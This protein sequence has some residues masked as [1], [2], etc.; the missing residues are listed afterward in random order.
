MYGHMTHFTP[1]R[2]ASLTNIVVPFSALP[3]RHQSINRPG[4]STSVHLPDF[5]GPK[6]VWTLEKRNKVPENLVAFEHAV[7]SA[8]HMALVALYQAGYVKYIVTQDV[9]SLHIKV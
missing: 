4:I 7:P 6:G 9:D 2:D 5:R 8:T 3:C 1:V